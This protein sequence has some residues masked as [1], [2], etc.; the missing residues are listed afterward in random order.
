MKRIAPTLALLF[1]LCSANG[2][3]ILSGPSIWNLDS[4]ETENAE[5]LKAERNIRFHVL[6]SPYLSPWHPNAY[7]GFQIAIQ[8]I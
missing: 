2:Q 6:Y 1:L 5:I 7:A 4:Y 3:D 8:D